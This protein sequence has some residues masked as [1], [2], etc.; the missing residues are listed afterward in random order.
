M[1]KVPLFSFGM[2][3]EPFDA[4]SSTT[5]ACNG[6]LHMGNSTCIKKDFISLM[7][8][9]VGIKSTGLNIIEIFIAKWKELWKGALWDNIA[10]C[11]DYYRFV[12]F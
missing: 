1:I 6:Y 12:L 4:F 2:R 5:V 7:W 8:D 10:Y 3:R 9:T 11:K